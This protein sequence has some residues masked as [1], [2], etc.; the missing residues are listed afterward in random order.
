MIFYLFM[1][2]P[3]KFSIYKRIRAYFRVFFGYKKTCSGVLH[4]EEAEQETTLFFA[5]LTSKGAKLKKELNLLLFIFA[6]LSNIV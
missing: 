4:S 6:H 5:H 1:Q 2:I 3:P